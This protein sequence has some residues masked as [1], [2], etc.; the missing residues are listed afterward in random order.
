MAQ[1]FWQSGDLEI[2]RS[3]LVNGI[4]AWFESPIVGFGP[5]SYSGI[6][7][8]FQDMEA[9]SVLI[10]WGISTGL[11]GMIALIWLTVWLA[12]CLWRTH[13]YALLGGL[14]ALAVFGQF[15]HVL[16]H[17]LVWAFLVLAA[18]LADCMQG[19]SHK[20]DGFGRE[21]FGLPIA[22]NLSS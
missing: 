21:R 22:R 8:A 16:R 1:T 3:L 11:I 20:A 14:L 2:R 19:A 6:D 17:P 18:R 10:D 12:R 15:H 4:K 9:H 7:G 13:H 5:G